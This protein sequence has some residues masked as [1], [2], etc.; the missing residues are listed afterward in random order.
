MP[1]T[2]EAIPAE[3]GDVVGDTLGHNTVTYVVEALTDHV[4]HLT[5]ISGEYLGQT[6][7]H[8]RSLVYLR[9]LVRKGVYE[10][11]PPLVY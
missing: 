9:L 5:Q 10:P 11:D 6:H 3:E 7:P 2:P 4:L 1:E 8:P